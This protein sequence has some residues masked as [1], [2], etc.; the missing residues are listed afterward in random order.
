M[1]RPPPR[2]P[3][4]KMRL[5]EVLENDYKTYVFNSAS[6]TYREHEWKGETEILC[7]YC[8]AKLHDMFPDGAC[9]YISRGKENANR[10]VK[11]QAT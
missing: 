1:H 2:C 7:P 11:K 4:C 3:Y 10:I 8:D 9:N 6:A 5:A